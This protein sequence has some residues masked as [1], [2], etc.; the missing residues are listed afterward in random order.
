LLL[1]ADWFLYVGAT[2]GALLP[3]VNPASAAPVFLAVTVGS[4]TRGRRK[5]ARRAAIYCAAILLTAL[6][7]GAVVLEF[8]GITLPILRIA[9]GLIVTQAGFGMMNPSSNP[10]VSL[11]EQ[12]EAAQMESVSFTPIAMPM[13][14]GPGSMAATIAMAT[15]AAGLV[16][17]SAI[18]VGIFVVA[19]ISWVV[20]Y[21]SSAILG[22]IGNSGMNVLTRVMGL[23]LICIGIQFIATGIVEGL[24]SEAMV[25]VLH[26][27]IVALQTGEIG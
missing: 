16:T 17:Y 1:V 19:F 10:R 25:R 15:Q 22:V 23:L 9:G 6:F 2:I 18:A 14:S 4:S 27:W 5:Q 12:E 20:L 11:S 21:S 7:A 8:F 13:L 3:I 24:T 26:P